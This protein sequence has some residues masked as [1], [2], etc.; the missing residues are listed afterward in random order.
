MLRAAPDPSQQYGGPCPPRRAVVLLFLAALIVPWVVIWATGGFDRSESLDAAEQMPPTPA[1]SPS[2]TPAPAEVATDGR[3][4][5]RLRVP[6]L[7]LDAPVSPVSGDSGELDPPKDPQLVGWWREGRGVGASEGAMVLTGHTVHAGDG[8]MDRL[9]N[10]RRN[11][12]V[13]VATSG[14]NQRYRVSGSEVLTR[15]ELAEKA[16]NLLSQSGKPRLLLITCSDWDGE[17][18]LTNTIV[19]ATPET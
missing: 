7:D 10:V 4:P 18:Y 11:D 19:T 15:A 14:S 1:A 13:I 16:D 12:V 17:H 8:V 5:T 2:T 9:G 6:H 3:E